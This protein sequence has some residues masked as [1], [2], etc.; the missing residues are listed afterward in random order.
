MRRE[1]ESVSLFSHLSTRL[2]EEVRPGA[3][4]IVD[5]FAHTRICLTLRLTGPAHAVNAARDELDPF[6]S[7]FAAELSSVRFPLSRDLED[8]VVGVLLTAEQRDQL[9]IEIDLLAQTDARGAAVLY[10]ALGSPH[11]HLRAS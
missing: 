1:T 11:R 3:G 7:P 10:E 5:E 2:L 4:E 6:E 9:D 8:R